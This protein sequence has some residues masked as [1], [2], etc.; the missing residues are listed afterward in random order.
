LGQKSEKLDGYTN[1]IWFCPRG[2]RGQW[3]TAKG[4][5]KNH[6]GKVDE[7][8]GKQ[9]TGNTESQEHRDQKA[10]STLI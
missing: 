9:S 8:N 10:G 7:D 3:Y 2:K 5:K 4:G 6:R 1:G